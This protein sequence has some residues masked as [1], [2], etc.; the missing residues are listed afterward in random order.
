[1]A[2][3]TLLDTPPSEL[4]RIAA[5]AGYDFVGLRV[6]PATP[7]EIR[8]DL[9]PGSEELRR[10]REAL[11]ETGLRVGDVEFLT[12][13]GH[14]GRADWLP[15]LESGRALG[16][17]ALIVT[18]SDADRARLLD[19]FARLAEDA[20][21]FDIVPV[22]EP[23][24]YQQVSTLRDAVAVARTTGIGV[25]VDTLHLVRGGS[26]L[27][28]LELLQG[29]PAPMIQLCDGLLRSPA[30]F[31]KV[32]LP[33]RMDHGVDP[34]SSEARGFR[35]SPGTGEFPLVEVLRARPGVALSLEA[36]DV[37]AAHEAPHDIARRLRRDTSRLLT[38][39]S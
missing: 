6:L 14:T 9:S 22:L 34:R 1:L 31:P 27:T 18:A 24:S 26:E 15:A 38:R 33:G 30:G 16:A 2:H 32:R 13:D 3:L 23:I 28:E 37:L 36:P 12:V 17:S 11:D 39:A 10:T 25:L 29:V 8:W 19:T 4:V 35:S 7:G 21:G 20:A 5:D